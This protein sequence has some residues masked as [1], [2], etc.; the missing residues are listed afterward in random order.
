VL[1]LGQRHPGCRFVDQQQLRILGQQHADF[2]PLLLPVR[3][4]AGLAIKLFARPI[5]GQRLDPVRIL[6]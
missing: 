3:Q 2:Q 5:F 6:A 4:L 1:A